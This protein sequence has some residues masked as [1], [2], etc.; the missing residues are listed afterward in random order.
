MTEAGPKLTLLEEVK[1]QAQV[2]VPVLQALRR[3][4]GEEP[5][6]RIVGEALRAWSKR[7]YRDIG[8]RNGGEPRAQF[9]AIWTDLR[10]RIGNAVDRESLRESAAV[11]DYNVTRCAYAEFFKALGEPELGTILLCEIDFHIADVG[12]PDVVLERT[13][14]IMKGAAYCDFRYRMKAGAS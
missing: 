8:K 4:I 3:E 13:Q 7:L 12:G 11:R 1:I 5:A 6:N 9:D 10:P 14:T 2:L